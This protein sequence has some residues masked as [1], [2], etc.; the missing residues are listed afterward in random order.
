MSKLLERLVLARLRPQL[1]TSVN[2]SQY[3]SAYGTGHST[4]TALLEVLDGS[5]V[6]D[7]LKKY[8]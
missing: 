1:Y 3:Q 4:E 8:L 7:T 2:F 6:Q 5:V